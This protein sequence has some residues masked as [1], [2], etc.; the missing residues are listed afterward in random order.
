MLIP[1]PGLKVEKSVGETDPEAVKITLGAI[2]LTKLADKIPL[3]P[4]LAFIV[5]KGHPV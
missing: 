2:S 1:R 3:V 5:P 4:I